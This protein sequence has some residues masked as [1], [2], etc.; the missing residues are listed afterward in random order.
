MEKVISDSVLL[1]SEIL[2]LS[3]P[4]FIISQSGV[5]RL[6]FFSF[7]NSSNRYVGILYNQIPVQTVVWVANR[8]KPLKDSSRILN[9]SDYGNLVVSNGK[10][11]VVWSSH[12]N[13]TAPNATTAQLLDSGNLVLSNGEDGP[14][15]L[16]ESFED[17]SNAFLETMKISNDVK[18]GRKVEIKSWK[19]PDDPSDGNF[20]LGIEPFN[21][22]E[23]VLSNNNKLYFRTGPWNGNIFIGVIMKTVYIDGFYI[24]ADNQ[25]QTY[26]ITYEFS[27]N[28]RLR[29]YELDSQG[30]FVKREW[31]A[32]KGDWINRY[33]TSQTE[34]SVYGQWGALGICDLTKQPI[35]SCLKG[36]KPRNI[37]EWSRGNWSR[38][39]FR[40][41]LLQCQRDKNNGSEAGQGDDDGFLKL[42]TMK[43][44]VF[45]N[46]SSINNGECKD[47]CMKNC[48]CVAYAYDAGIGCMI[49]SGDLIDMQK[50]S[51]H[52]VDLYFRL[53]SSELDKGKSNKVIV[54][55]AIIV[56]TVTIT[57]MILFLWC[58]LKEEEGNKNTNRSNS[59][60]TKEMQ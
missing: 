38:G 58:W 56:G 60:S 43:V 9:I 39:C 46:R 16:W 6:G 45:P 1:A 29:Y 49:W 59:N 11:E 36:F 34:S 13:N 27:D 7:A 3:Y 4:E 22:P 23:V 17:P 52:G 30:K 24:V 14:S 21:I 12:V 15:S 48:S 8:N 47:Q 10:A 42:K 40:T 53:P 41:T 32:G 31:D 5:F 18:K 35:C 33:S 20:S 2:L 57:I 25:Q 44:P 37:E 55:A 50:F 26:Y 19:S 51:T 28:S 54:I